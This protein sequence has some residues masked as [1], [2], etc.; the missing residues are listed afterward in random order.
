M[1]SLIDACSRSTGACR[2]RRAYRKLPIRPDKMTGVAV[3]IALQV[4]LV[5]RLGLPELPG[6]G[7]LRDDLTRPQTGG[8]DVGDGLL[9]DPALLVGRIEDGRAVTQPPIIALTV[10]CRRIVN[11]EKE[12]EDLPVADRLGVKDDFDR[13]GV[14]SVI[15]I[16]CV[17]HIAA[18]IAYPRGNDAGIAPQQILD[19]PKTAAGQDGA[20]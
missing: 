11:L 3:R 17:R 12:F 5:L 14:R 6:G 9:G 1:N 13:F 7:D 20:L 18:R 8:L 15:A 10:Q 19:A 16:S 4:V 2:T